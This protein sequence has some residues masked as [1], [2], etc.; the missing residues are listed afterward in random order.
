MLGIVI[1]GYANGFYS[2]IHSSLTADELA[3]ID[4][5]YSYGNIL[6]EMGVWLAGQPALDMLSPLSPETK[7]GAE[8]L[9]WTF[10]A[11]AYFVLLNLLIAIFNSAYERVISN[12]ISEWLFIRL[13]L[14]LE[15]EKDFEQP[16]VRAYYAQLEQ[17]DGRRAGTAGSTITQE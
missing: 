4:F 2:L 15:F 16:G 13:G 11:T 12:S 8:V 9:F 7:F 5:D 17:R 6:S 1:L 14:L 10:L 3:Q